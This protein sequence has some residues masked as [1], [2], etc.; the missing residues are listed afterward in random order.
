MLVTR[1]TAEI[2][3][4]I[5]ELR[6]AYPEQDKLIDEILHYA[7]YDIYDSVDAMTYINIV[8]AEMIKLF[9]T[10]ELEDFNDRD[11]TDKE[12]SEIIT[13]IKRI[14]ENIDIAIYEY[15]QYVLEDYRL[16]E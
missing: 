6:L 2:E 12:F 7:R 1:T 10:I 9:N 15:V 4:Y 11:I 14:A 3:K 8:N 5:E 13:N 16:E